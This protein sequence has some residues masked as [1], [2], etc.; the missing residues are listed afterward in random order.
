M[1]DRRFTSDKKRIVIYSNEINELDTN[2]I[3]FRSS[4]HPEL[5]T[6][7]PAHQGVLITPSNPLL[8]KDGSIQVCNGNDWETFSACL[9][10]IVEHW[11]GA[12]GS[13]SPNSI[14]VARSTYNPDF[15]GVFAEIDR[16][17]K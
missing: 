13:V 12:Q 9:Y 15:K 5:R 4:A 8:G 11:Y 2:T 17:L 7:N 10:T 1:F 14:P 3:D 16:V 6:I